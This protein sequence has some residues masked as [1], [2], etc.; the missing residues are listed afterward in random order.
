MSETPNLDE[1]ISDGWYNT[2]N[3]MSFEHRDDLEKLAAA[4]SELAALK[5]RA[6]DLE[7]MLRSRLGEPRSGAAVYGQ[8]G[9]FYVLVK[10]DLKERPARSIEI[11]EDGTGLPV[12]TDAAREALRKAVETMPCLSSSHCR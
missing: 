10:G 2:A 5:Q 1:V 8:P 7:L 11:G 9:Y 4:R 6:E 3:R 12:L